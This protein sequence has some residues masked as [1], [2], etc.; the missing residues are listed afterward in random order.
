LTAGE[1]DFFFF[2]SLCH[3]ASPRQSLSCTFSSFSLTV[4]DRE[5]AFFER[6]VRGPFFFLGSKSSRIFNLGS[7]FFFFSPKVRNE[8]S[9][10]LKESGKIGPVSLSFSLLPS[11]LMWN[12]RKDPLNLNFLFPSS[13]P[14][15]LS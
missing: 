3:A 13:L 14:P 6:R 12:R 2:S 8:N 10:S 1:D 15:P 9:L 4:D 11:F 7:S 5:R